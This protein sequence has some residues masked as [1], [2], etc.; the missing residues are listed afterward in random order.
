[1]KMNIT[2]LILLSVLLPSVPARADVTQQQVTEL[3]VATFNRAPDAAGLYY[4][5]NDSFADDPPRA[6]ERIA[7]SFFDQPET[8]SLYPAGNTNTQ[9]VTSIY[10]NLFN[11]APDSAGLAYWIGRDGLG[12]NMARSVMIEALKNGA[13]G[14]DATIIANKAEVGFYYVSS[15]IEGN[16]FSLADVT[17]D[18]ATVIEAKRIIDSLKGGNAGSIILGAP[19]QLTAQNVLPAG[20]MIT[21]NN[22]GNPLH[23]MKITV[24]PGAYTEAKSFRVSSSPITSHTFG[25][26]FQ[27]LTPMIT[28]DNGG[29]H[30]EESMM[31]Q[32]P[33]Q[34]PAD[35][36]AMAFF[37]DENQGKL[38][39][40]Q[41]IS[42][43]TDS[44]TVATR[45]FSSFTVTGIAQ[46]VLDTYLKQG[47]RSGFMPGVDDWSFVNRGSYIAPGG[48]CAGQSLGA[49]WYFTAQPVG[50]TPLWGSYD[51]NYRD[52]RT[53]D[54]WQDD[55]Y[56]YRFC[57]I[58]QKDIDWD[59]F[60]V[61]FWNE[62]Q[63]R[64]WRIVDNQWKLVN[65][66]AL[67]AE[68]TRNMFALA[69][70]LTEREPQFV[71]IYSNAGGGHAMIVYAVTQD[72]LHIA[73]PNYPG[74]TNRLIYF[75]NG[76]FYPYFSGDN[77]EEINAGRGKNYEH[78]L[79]LAKSTLMP[80]EKIAER[81]LEAQYGA[82]GDNV[83]P[84]YQIT[85]L[86]KETGLFKLLEDDQVFTESK[87]R[88]AAAGDGTANIGS[89]LYRDGKVL[90]FDADWRIDL[91]PGDNLLG[92][93]VLGKVGD[94]W[95]YVDFV[96]FNV[97]YESEATNKT[98]GI[99][100]QPRSSDTPSSYPT[101]FGGAFDLPLAISATGQ[102]TFDFTKRI[103]LSLEV[104]VYHFQGT[105]SYVG[106]MLTLDGSW[107][108]QA[109]GGPHTT[110]LSQDDY[111][112]FFLQTRG[113]YDEP[114]ATTHATSKRVT[115][116]GV[117]ES[118]NQTVYFSVDDLR[119]LD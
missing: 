17:D 44:I 36:F 64:V 57:S 26:L 42:V 48:H 84:D 54:F 21:V 71:G 89:L 107:T 99:D 1:M 41:L 28:I 43:G 67:S 20:G 75:N 109:T 91:N 29:E 94:A 87:I 103:E 100:L 22:L 45:H 114:L 76:D 61:D 16:D 12:G 35:S 80:W 60:S 56:A 8:Q 82:I 111:G 95:E 15:G 117:R 88:I 37:Y 98:L 3:Y 62:A 38:E 47:I 49:M 79:Y 93:S 53:L 25:E 69:M 51:N 31:V 5:V 6:I 19:E 34:I 40:M 116:Y 23:A 74:N 24:P 119:Q 52:W 33:V 96:Y 86:D 32:I 27:P 7:A 39:P 50:S 73:D 72:A 63:G 66:P 70:L 77:W 9:F 46:S 85:Y 92:L 14:V 110:Y 115:E 83:F 59:S 97:I 108:C 106:K 102:I 113:N 4:W 90:A 58:L 101:I 118:L 18:P 68:A 81:W 105:G 2:V 112:T 11:R 30:S 78:I 65:V 55:S 104:R 10:H 13:L